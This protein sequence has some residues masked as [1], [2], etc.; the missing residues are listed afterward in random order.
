MVELKTKV[1]EKSVTEFLARIKDERRRKD[2]LTVMRIMQSV[3]KARP[4]MWGPS[5]VGFGSY[6]YTYASGREGDWPLTGFSPRK[7]NLTVYIMTGFR[8]RDR[9]MK[10]LGKHTTGY[11][12]LYLNSLEDTNKSVLKTLIKSS[13]TILKKR[14]GRGRG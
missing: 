7:Q 10:K 3:T 9:L 2:C 12:C 1:T 13:V 14:S 4:K 6:H 11:S 5:I 8:G